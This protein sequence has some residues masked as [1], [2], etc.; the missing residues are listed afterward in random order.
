VGADVVDVTKGMGLDGRIGSSFLN[1]GIGY[2][3]SC[4]PKD[5]RSLIR[6]A[7]SLGVQIDLVKEVVRTNDAQPGVLIS[8]MRAALGGSVSGKTIAVLGLAFKGNTD[9][10]RDSKALDIVRI[11]V[12][13]GAVVRAYD[14]VAMANASRI[15]PDIVYCKNAYEAVEAADAVAV[16]TEW[17]EFKLLNFD[18][19]LAQMKGN[20]LF[21][22]RN[23]YD[24]KKVESHGLKYF[25]VGRS[26]NRGDCIDPHATSITKGADAVHRG[27]VD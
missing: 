18:R 16:V 24:P 10:L 9:D 5:T 7:E 23:L 27:S 22:G 2:G 15:L 25:G 21:D 17:N 14:P 8:K 3:G 26:A 20:L 11:L 13:E 1:A 19:V 12:G 4:F 6:T